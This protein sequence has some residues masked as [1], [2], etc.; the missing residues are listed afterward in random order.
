[1]PELRKDAATYD[2][3]AKVYLERP[4]QTPDIIDFVAEYM[5]SNNIGLL[6]NRLLTIAGESLIH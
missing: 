6:T 1:M 4:C 2:P 3:A 5:D